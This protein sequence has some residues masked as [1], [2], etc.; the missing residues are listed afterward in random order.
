MLHYSSMF[1]INNNTIVLWFSI[2][3][4]GLSL[5]HYG[6]LIFLTNGQKDDASNLALLYLKMISEDF[7]NYQQN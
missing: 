4:F 1:D 3:E 6:S 2:P 5:S 7:K